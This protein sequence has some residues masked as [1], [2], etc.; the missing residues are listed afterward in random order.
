VLTIEENGVYPSYTRAELLRY[1]SLFAAP[2]IDRDKVTKLLLIVYALGSV[3]MAVALLIYGH[4]GDL[5]KTT[6]GRILAAA[7]LTL[8]LGALLSVR[9]P[10]SHRVVFKMIIVFT[11]LAAGAIVYRL[12]AGQHVNDPSWLLLP[13]A[14]VAPILFTIFYPRAPRR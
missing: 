3:A 12:A 11:A 4:A 10:W 13:F 6:S 9:D 5:A 2:M 1:L 8:G 14:V 7:L